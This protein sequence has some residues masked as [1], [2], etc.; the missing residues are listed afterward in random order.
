M[1]TTWKVILSLIVVVLVVLAI[2]SAT[3]T[4]TPAPT[5]VAAPVVE[6]P[7]APDTSDQALESD[8]AAIDRE[9]EESGKDSDLVEQSL[10]DQSI[11]Q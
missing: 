4:E 9:I 1:T 6:A 7:P 11:T 10:A 8:T 3:P 2:R 5:P